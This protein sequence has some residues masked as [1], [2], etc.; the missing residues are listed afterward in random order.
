MPVNLQ[1]DLGPRRARSRRRFRWWRWAAGLGLPVAGAC[2][3]LWVLPFWGW[4]FNAQ[5]HTRPPLTPAWALECWL[6]E[7]DA[8]T[9]E[10]VRELLAGYAAHDLPVR[11]VLLDSPWSTRYN[12]FTVDT[13]RY[14]DPAKFFGDLQT[15]GYRVVLWMTC[16]VNSRNKD[17]AVR[18]ASDFYEHARTNG[19]LAGD[20]HEVSWWKGRGGFLDYTHPD[21]LR[22]WHGLQQPLFDL[23]LDGW[24]LDGTDTLFS[25]P[26]FLPYQ[27]THAGWL[28]TR[29]YMDRYNREEYRHGLTQN[30][31]FIVLT[32]AIDDRYFPL[33]HPEGF[34]P[35]DAAPVTW[36]GDRT[37]EWS[38][39]G[40]GGAD[41]DA[42]RTT[43]SL[44]DRGFEGALRDILA[45]AAKGYG[46]VGDDVAGY[47]GKEPIPPRLYIR[48]AQF[49]AFTGL[50]LNGGHGE[51][52]LWQRTAEELAIIRRYAWLHTELV[53]Y[54]YTLVARHHEGGLPLIR[55]VAGPYH[56]RLGDDLLIAP[57]YRDQLTNAV[58][59]PAGRWRHL[60]HDGKVLTGPTNFTR[61]FALDNFPAY[62]RDGANLP[63]N[64]TRTYTGFGDTNS[65]NLLT[66][67]IWPHG[68]N[69]FTVTH[70][71]RSGTTTLRVEAGTG[72]SLTLAGVAKPHRLRILWPE[73]PRVVRRDGQV[74]AEGADW[75]YDAADTRL[76][77]TS[78]TG[79]A[80]AY[81]VE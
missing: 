60:F 15:N 76:W 46:V 61:A 19:F 1:L 6:W 25:G 41:A 69:E 57:I 13:N 63:L 5:R 37:H 29:G 16:M 2:Y 44:R 24:K 53:P 78:P 9:A 59:L 26:G 35:L 47:H 75:R 10:A 72:L 50:F 4:P 56:Y 17:T 64:V 3:F 23:G 8:N 66:W 73:R 40:G 34:A 79:N 74:L 49:A 45:S 7:D 43:A 20:G 65:A 39:R 12:D 80:A 81:A 36:V 18:A 31:E 21:A 48:W 70:P 54:L 68:T 71:D 67:A 51:R 52:R 11:T 22:W 32:R 58:H 77:I 28:S 30:P 62:V 55:P 42:V 38:S 33:S 14:P 27:H